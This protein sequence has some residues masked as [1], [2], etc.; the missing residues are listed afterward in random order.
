[1]QCT[2]NIQS[3]DWSA[4]FLVALELKEIQNALRD[5]PPAKWYQLGVQLG[6]TPDTLSTIECNHPRDVQRC[7][8]EVLLWWLKNAEVISWDNLAQ[9]LEGIEY[10]DLADKLR[11]KG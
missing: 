7:K 2:T 6:V 8:S 9:A 3:D 10:G 1:M 11:K 4:L 5:V